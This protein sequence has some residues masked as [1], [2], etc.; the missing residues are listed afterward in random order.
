MNE[1]LKQTYLALLWETLTIFF[2]SFF[3]GPVADIDLNAWLPFHLEPARRVAR[4]VFVYHGMADPFVC[5]LLF[6]ALYSLKIQAKEVLK[7][8]STGYM[9]TGKAD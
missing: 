1:D 6:L 2:L 7:T 8:A 9:L 4:I 3:S 5:F